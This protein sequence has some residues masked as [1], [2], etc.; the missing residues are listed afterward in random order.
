MKGGCFIKGKC[1]LEEE[2]PKEGFYKKIIFPLMHVSRFISHVRFVR[3][4]KVMAPGVRPTR[5][6]D[7]T[8]NSCIIY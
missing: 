8:N 5:V 3:S 6:W 4:V 1:S 2:R 7:V